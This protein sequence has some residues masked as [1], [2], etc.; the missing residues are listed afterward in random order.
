MHPT[1]LAVGRH[2]AAIAKDFATREVNLMFIVATAMVL[3]GTCADLERLFEDEDSAAPSSA[4][5]APGAISTEQIEY[6]LTLSRACDVAWFARRSGEWGA[7]SS[8]QS[9]IYQTEWVDGRWSEPALVTF[10][11]PEGDED[12]FLSPDG[13]HLYFTSARSHPDRAGERNDQDIWVV[14]RHPNGWGIPE[15]LAEAINSE[16]EEFS[17][18]V[19]ADGTLYF[20]SGRPGGVGMGDIYVSRPERGRYRQAEILPTTVNSPL[21]EWNVSVDPAGRM[22]FVEASQRAGNRSTYGDLYLSRRDPTSGSWSRALPIPML[23]T[24]G[25]EL[26]ARLSPGGNFLFYASSQTRDGQHTDIRVARIKDVLADASSSA[27]GQQNGMLVVANRSEHMLTLIDGD[28]YNVVARTPSGVGPHEIA[29]FE[30]GRVIIPSYGVFNDVQNPAAVPRTLTFTS[31]PSE[32]VEIFDP[33][34][35]ATKRFRLDGCTRPHG[36]ASHPGSRRFWLTCEEERAVIEVDA[37][38]GAELARWP[39]R[40]AGSH[41]VLFDAARNRLYTGNVDAGSVSVIHRKT[42]ST[43]IIETAAGAEGLAMTID[44]RSLWVAN[45]QADSLSIIDLEDLAVTRSIGSGGDFPVKIRMSPDGEEAWVVHN[46]SREATVFDVET[47]ERL[48]TIELESAPLGLLISPDGRRVFI[49]LP[50]LDRIS[51]FDRKSRGR[52]GSFSPG[53]EPDGLAWIKGR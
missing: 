29:A 50:R 20:A 33:R 7:G 3:A 31:R 22:L 34:S 36:V 44:G 37:A 30:D 10:S 12:P 18:A 52:I 35:G 46:A 9:G 26:T 5:F 45:T 14:E 38:S 8:G 25:S 28:N 11:S 4:V 13:R 1:H 17:P 51:V 40:Q 2:R 23:N 6:A 19:A 48:H 15:R 27:A 24:T 39:T 43:S 42:G 16:A 47:L 21:G 32:G 53:I 49:T 41:M